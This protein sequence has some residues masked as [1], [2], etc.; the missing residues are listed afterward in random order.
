MLTA[1]LRRFAGWPALLSAASPTVHRAD[2]TPAR[3][4]LPPRHISH[5]IVRESVILAGLLSLARYMDVAKLPTAFVVVACS[6][7]GFLVF[8]HSGNY[9]LTSTH[10]DGPTID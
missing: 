3:R 5:R 9:L 7:R 8:S 1:V 6:S 10:W 2:L 4:S